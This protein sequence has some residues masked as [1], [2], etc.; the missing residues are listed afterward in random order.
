MLCCVGLYCAVWG[1]TGLCCAGLCCA[2]LCCAVWGYAVL[3]GAVLCVL[4][5]A[6]LCWVGLC[7]AVWGCAG[8]CTL[9]DQLPMASH[10]WNVLTVNKAIP[11]EI[12]FS[13]TEG[14]T[15]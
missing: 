10:H 1:C 11:L 2:G 14:M 6:G 12:G 3:Y 4:C 8:L 5:C 15:Q 7:C 13:R 9:G